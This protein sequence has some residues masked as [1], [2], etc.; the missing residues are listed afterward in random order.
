MKITEKFALVLTFS[1][2]LLF[3]QIQV[4]F[5]QD[6]PQWRGPNRSGISPHHLTPTSIPDSLSKIWQIQIGTGYSSPVVSNKKIF[7]HIKSCLTIRIF[8]L[9]GLSIT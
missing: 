7:L 6:W 9:L 2:A 5:A 1:L 3:C 8:Y 4:T